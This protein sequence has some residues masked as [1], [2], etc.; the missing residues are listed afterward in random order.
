MAT[1]PTDIQFGKVIGLYI[2]AIADTADDP[3]RL[4]NP[5]AASGF[6]KFTPVNNI[7]TSTVGSPV[8]SVIPQ[9][10]QGTLVDGALTDDAGAD[11]VWLVAGMYDVT[12]NLDGGVQIPSFRFVVG[13]NQTVD[14][15]L[16]APLVPNPAQKF[17][18]NEQVYIDTL[19]QADRAETEAD[20]AEAAAAGAS[21]MTQAQ[22]DARYF[23][24]S[25]LA[26]SQI[27]ARGSTG[28]VGGLTFSNNPVAFNVPQRGSAGEILVPTT[29]TAAQHAV[30]KS[31]TD[32]TFALVGR[33]VA[34]GTGLTGGGTLAADRTLALSATSIASLAKADT[35]VQPAAL[36]SKADLVSGVIPT[37][38]I[39]SLAL[40]TRVSVASQAAML[41]LTTTQVQPGD[42][43]VRTDTGVNYL[44]GAADPSV[45]SNWI[46]LDLTG[47]G[48][49]ASVNGQTGAVTLGATDVAAVPASAAGNSSVFVK[50]SSG[51]L[52]GVSYTSA[53][54]ASTMAQRDSAGNIAVGTAV[55]SG[56]AANKN[57][58]DTTAVPITSAAASQVHARNSSGTEVGLAY[59]SAATANAL[60]QRDSAGQANFSA[61]TATTH[62][63]TKS[64]A[65]GLGDHSTASTAS[66]AATL[67]IIGASGFQRFVLGGNIT[68]SLPGT[69]PSSGEGF[70]RTYT[71]VQDATGGRTITWPTGIKW[72]SG[73]KP[74]L[75][76][77]ANAIDVITI[78][79]NGT[80]W[81]G[82]LGAKA[83]A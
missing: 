13:A 37:S 21:G 31:Y 44:L 72:D 22:A 50:G 53:A 3:D 35:A 62:A 1:L 5:I 79:W 16:V 58:V 10:Q 2:L 47:G 75:S 48:A 20:R 19:F 17:V 61:P 68:V 60:V 80:E 82:F 24:S 42:I 38:Q 54:T 33:A 56:D 46:A 64:Y 4:P 28:T 29:P 7:V 81:I 6:I 30:S 70:S 36:A 69:A 39:P 57:Y 73:V 76:T 15:S 67:A 41:A 12:F 51:V 18:V 40:T 14:L 66:L 63:A 49:V 9:T 11:G 59:T 34:A 25:V 55:N 65:D 45:L 8:A 52:G 26:N 71:F 78:M 27:L 23:Q 32:S 77:A 74:T 43:A 83:A